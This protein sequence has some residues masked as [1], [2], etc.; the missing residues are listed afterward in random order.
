MNMAV[1][2]VLCHL[3]DLRGPSE[4]RLPELATG[5]VAIAQDAIMMFL[6][7][8]ARE[9]VGI[10]NTTAYLEEID[11]LRRQLEVSETQLHKH[12]GSPSENFASLQ[13]PS[14][15]SHAASS[16]INSSR[17]DATVKRRLRGIHMATGHGGGTQF[18]GPSSA[19]YFIGRLSRYLCATLQQP[20]LIPQIQLMSASSSLAM[21]TSL[22]GDGFEH[23]D[24]SKDGST[25]GFSLTGF[26][27][28]YFLS[29]FWQSYHCTV[30]I[31]D[32][33]QFK[34]HYTDLWKGPGPTRK[35]SALVDI[36]LALCMQYGV[37]YAPR[38]NARAMPK[39]NVDGSDATIAGRWLYH[40]SQ[41]LLQSEMESPSIATL[42]AQ[43]FSVY[44]L[45][46][47]SFQNMAHS[48][49]ALALRTAHMLGLHLEPPD[50]LSRSQK[51][52]RKR[53]WWTLYT[54]ESKACMKL[55]RPWSTRLSDVS[56]SMPADDHELAL[57]SGSNFTSHGENITWLTYSIQ[58]TRLLLAA[59]SIYVSFY[60]ECTDHPVED[61]TA[62]LGTDLRYSENCAGTLASNM[63]NLRD[64]AEQVPD[65]LKMKRKNFIHPF[66][67][68]E[69]PLDIE[70][71]APLWLQRQRLLLELL[72]HNLSMNLYRPFIAFPPSTAHSSPLA[73]ANAISC[74]SH[75]IAITNIVHQTLDETDVVSGWHEAFQWQWNATLSMI[76]YVVAYPL[77]HSTER[78]R[79]AIDRSVEVFN[80]F[81]NNL[82]V[83]AS[84]A[85][86]TRDLL[87]KVDLLINHLKDDLVMTTTSL[88]DDVTTLQN[89]GRLMIQDDTGMDV[90]N[91]GLADVLDG[92]FPLEDYNAITEPMNT[93]FPRDPFDGFDPLWA[94]LDSNNLW[95][96]PQEQSR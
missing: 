68:H 6:A 80:N 63:K 44:Y 62:T 46:N 59:R 28:D 54:V 5:V 69:A 29:L 40:R 85:N 38:G 64:W 75:A 47:A 45:C 9:E 88:P 21:P 73:E 3:H 89:S 19:F 13:A 84:A 52:L 95:I 31:V 96:L 93:A 92:E 36:I 77:H 94:G 55:G 34:S 82:A 51:E 20:E 81:G 53:L 74:V 22:S 18:Y 76:G 90:S 71:F 66:S 15:P 23:S 30:Q 57:V 49:L 87:S 48:T 2:E 91:T 1:G 24:T 7:T 33:A 72:Y 16:D 10:A 4:R 8:I 78:A 79:K 83:A 17:A 65:A 11:R 56:C 67:I 25:T 32:E 41:N 26:Q 43:I 42:Q 12:Q 58:S 35:P 14:N 39:M 37:A 61:D 50:H 27:E 60:D 70:I 86:I